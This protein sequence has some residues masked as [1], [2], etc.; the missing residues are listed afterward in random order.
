MTEPFTTTPKYFRGLCVLART[1]AHRA[2]PQGAGAV[3]AFALNSW[4]RWHCVGGRRDASVYFFSQQWKPEGWTDCFTFSACRDLL[5]HQH[6]PTFHSGACTPIVTQLCTDYS[7]NK[8]QRFSC[9]L[10]HLFL[11]QY[12]SK[13][14]WKNYILLAISLCCCWN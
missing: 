5:L 9:F 4:Y 13:D 6:I 2:L 11:F 3:G 7:A 10:S 8:F 12:A 1:V 14:D